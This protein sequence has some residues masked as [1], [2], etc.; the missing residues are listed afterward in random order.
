MRFDP[1]HVRKLVEHT[2]L[3]AFRGTPEYMKMYHMKKDLC[4]TEEG[5]EK[6]A[7]YLRELERMAVPEPT[8]TVDKEAFDK[9]IHELERQLKEFPENN[10]LIINLKKQIK[11]E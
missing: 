10:K 1:N 4:G 11:D 7:M 6:W 9:V 3:H 5:R 8:I 2:D